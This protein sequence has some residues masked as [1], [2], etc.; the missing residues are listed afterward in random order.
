[1]EK[2]TKVYNVYDFD[3]L[4]EN[5]KNELIEKEK[6]YIKEDYIEWYLYDDMFEKAHELLKK[7]FK[8]KAIFKNIYYDLSYCQGDGAMI[9]FDL[10]YYNKDIKI[11]QYGHYCHELSFSIDTYDYLTDKQ[12]EQLKEK[13]YNMNKELSKYG[14]RLIE[15]EPDNSL[16]LENLRQNKYLENGKIF[17]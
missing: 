14:Y 4:D 13:I 9:E 16:V 6:E 10:S 11:R 3:E 7:Y 5:I 15:E 1:M 8:G 17:N 12:E 2:I